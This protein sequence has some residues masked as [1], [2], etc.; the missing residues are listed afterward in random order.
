MVPRWSSRTR[1]DQSGSCGRT[2]GSSPKLL[3]CRNVSL[4]TDAVRCS[5]SSTG[6]GT[7]VRELTSEGVGLGVVESVKA[8]VMSF[9]FVPLSLRCFRLLA[10]LLTP[11][12]QNV[13]SED[14]RQKRHSWSSRAA[15]VR[16]ALTQNREGHVKFP[17]EGLFHMCIHFSLYSSN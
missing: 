4:V 10:E 2:H 6:P 5:R 15:N 17:V 14:H 3:S 8:V 12:W 11:A 1:L 13:L 9:C 16:H 7:E